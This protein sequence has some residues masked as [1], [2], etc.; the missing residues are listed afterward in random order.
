M[1][2][3]ISA[4]SHAYAQPKKVSLLALKDISLEIQSGKF[5]TLIGPSG[6]G[7]STLLR[8]LAGLLTPSEGVISLGGLT[9]HEATAQKQ[10]SWM[11]QK[12][13]LLPWRS[14]YANIALAQRINPC[15]SRPTISPQELLDLVNLEDFKTAHPFTLSGGMQQRVALA[16]SLASGAAIWL[17]DE[18]FTALDELTRERLTLE[19]LNLWQRFR[20]TVLWVT[21]SIQEAVL[22]ADRVLVMSPRPGHIHAQLDLSLSRPRDATTIEFQGVVRRLR[23]ELALR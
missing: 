20:T 2:I 19:M 4:L 10:I 7:K 21:H 5:I 17:M 18:P 16:R 11:A 13:A 23:E 6:C 12:P 9:P 15:N 3:S 22:L 1:D 14:V 8:I